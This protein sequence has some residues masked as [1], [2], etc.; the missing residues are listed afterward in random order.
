M[1][2]AA[3]MQSLTRDQLSNALIRINI[4]RTQEPRNPITLDLLEGAIDALFSVSKRL[5]VY[6]SLAPGGPN[7]GLLADL[8]GEWTKGWVTGELLE[9]G[10]SAAM[11]YPALRWCPEGHEIDAHLFVS[12]DLPGM[13]R[14]LDDFEGLEYSRI[15]APFW[16]PDGEVSVGNIY[17]MECELEG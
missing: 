5:I 3:S 8:T 6:G 15:W 1:E 9:R 13:W 14:R 12:E 10:W 4:L 17:A 7:H 16:T 2:Q 11:S